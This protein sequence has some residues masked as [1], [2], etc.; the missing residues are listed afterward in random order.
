MFPMLRVAFALLFGWIALTRMEAQPVVEA[1][2]PLA[3]RISS[4]LPHRATVSLEFHDLTQPPQA[5]WSSFRGALQDELRKAGLEIATAQPES[6]L[7]VTVS[8]NP[9]GLLFVAEAFTK[10]TQ[11]VAMLEWN[12]PPTSESKPRVKIVKQSLW[13]QADPILDF[14]L[15]D[16]GSQLLVLSI[17]KLASYQRTGGKWTPGAQVSLTL[18]RPMPRDERGRLEIAAAALHVYLPGTTCSGVLQPSVIFACSPRIELWPLN[19][20]DAALQVRWVTDRNLLES[21]GVRGGFYNAG[22]GLFASVDGR[23]E[24]RGSEPVGG[25]DGWGSDLASIENPCGSNPLV[26]ATA[27]S[28]SHAADQVQIYEM[29]NGQ[30]IPAS[31]ALPLP[32]PVS[33]LW[34]AETPGQATLVVRNSK[35]GNYEASRLGL[36]CAE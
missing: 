15:T 20:R 28:D 13:D 5:E 1:A 24:Q 35:T 31:E 4:L 23:I 16:S 30:G 10:D 36:A 27:A 33:A 2:S 22:G 14:A 25:T 12:A 19:A 6:R 11:Q 32:G 8:E 7:R 9:H 29:T 18:A 21:E 26:I 17:G 3:A 34:P